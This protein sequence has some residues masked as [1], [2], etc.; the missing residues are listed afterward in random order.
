MWGDDDDN[1]SYGYNDDKSIGRSKTDEGDFLHPRFLCEDESLESNSCL[2]QTDLTTILQTSLLPSV[3]ET[4]DDNNQGND[5]MWVRLKKKQTKREFCVKARLKR[6]RSR[7][8][9]EKK[10]R[11]KTVLTIKESRELPSNLK[12]HHHWV[13]RSQ[14]YSRNVN[15]NCWRSF[16]AVQGMMHPCESLR[17]RV[18]V[19]CS[20]THSTRLS[21]LFTQ[22]SHAFEEKVEGNYQTPAEYKDTHLICIRRE[23]TRIN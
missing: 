7:K 9:R 17:D 10:E 15:G 18:F 22:L 8:E 21:L 6:R 13:Q 11:N 14:S 1:C 4:Q 12:R 3:D 2:W 5:V 19:I 16:T 23:I 20:V